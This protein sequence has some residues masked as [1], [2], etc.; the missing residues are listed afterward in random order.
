MLHL[1]A[2]WWQTIRHEAALPLGRFPTDE[3]IRVSRTR[4]DYVRFCRLNSLLFSE[5]GIHE[6]EAALIE[7]I[8]DCGV[9]DG[10]RAIRS[11]NDAVSQE[12][13]RP[14]LDA[15]RDAQADAS[16]SELAELARMS[17]Y[18]LIRAFR[19]AT[20][21][22]PHAWQLNQRINRAREC[23]QAGKDLARIAHDLG[24][25]DQSHFQRVF[26]AHTG[27]TPGSYRT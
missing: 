9:G 2:Q 22:T 8:G 27:V 1:D 18:Q 15:L 3:P 7:F 5:A 17:R 11:S 12:R 23:L 4:A 26:K 20:G 16:L 24:F 19:N 25:S 21:F 10:A 13:I 14:V 6:K